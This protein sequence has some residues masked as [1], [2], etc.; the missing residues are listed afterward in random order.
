[1]FLLDNTNWKGNY[2]K[3]SFSEVVHLLCSYIYC[4]SFYAKCLCKES[5]TMKLKLCEKYVTTIEVSIDIKFDFFH[6]SSSF[7]INLPSKVA[8]VN[9]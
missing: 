8:H 4:T 5:W 1:M 7:Q 2:K 3:A 9:L 6:S